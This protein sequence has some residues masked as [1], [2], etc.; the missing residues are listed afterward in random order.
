MRTRGAASIYLGLKGASS[1]FSALIYTVELIY[2]AQ[3]VGLNPLQLVLAGTLQRSICFVFQA[4][5]G[6]LADAYSRRWA[7]VLGL[8]FTGVGFL[9]EGI[10]P[11][12]AA[13]L[14][15]QALW[16]FGATLMDGADTAWIADEVG[17]ERAGPL[18]LRATQ[19]G[20]FATLPGIAL[21]AALGSVRLNLPILV[22]GG[23]FIFLGAVLAAVM[24]ERRFMPTLYEARMSWRKVGYTL[25]EGMLIVRQSPVLLSVMGIAA[26]AGVCNAGFGQLWQYHLLHTFSFPAL[27]GL[28]PIVWFGIIEIVIALTSV[29]GIEVARRG[30]DTSS[31]RSVAWALFAADGLAIVGILGFA[32]AGQFAL[33]L[34]ALWLITTAHGPRIPLEQAWMNQNLPAS[35]RATVFSLRGQVAAFAAIAGGP[36]LGVI[37]TA[38]GTRTALL[39]AGCIFSPALLLYARI[40]RRDTSLAAP[41]LPG[42][43]DTRLP[44]SPR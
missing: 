16:G 6:A 43:E 8:C 21:S 30:S 13:V 23:L 25:R 40:I 37:A 12:F 2:Q 1:L 17:T 9:V 7:V 41:G 11:A 42:T 31:H 33:A 18:Y 29:V 27:G 20:W 24:P 22:G 19:I 34:A 14:V 10:I 15:A 28:A 38:F 39:A 5:T 4:P 3:T 26:L 36:A 35:V 44:A 32:V